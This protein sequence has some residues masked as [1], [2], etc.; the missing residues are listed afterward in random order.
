MQ[1]PEPALGLSDGTFSSVVRLVSAFQQ[2]IASAIRVEL[3]V[4]TQAAYLSLR[5]ARGIG[6]SWLSTWR[7][8][9]PRGIKTR[10]GR[11][12]SGRKMPSCPT[13][14]AGGL[15]VFDRAGKIATTQ[16]KGAERF[17]GRLIP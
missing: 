13:S 5:K 4:A 12:A 2:A 3:L 10:K 14:C 1:S 7:F 8:E 15:L 9:P 16:E 11:M 17:A 6:Q